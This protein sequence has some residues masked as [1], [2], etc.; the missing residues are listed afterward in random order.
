MVDQIE[1]RYP[2]RVAAIEW[3]TGSSYP[4][5]CA[6]ARARW[7]TYPPPYWYNGG[8]VYATPWAWIDGKNRG[9]QSGSWDG[10]VQQQ[11]ADSAE[12]GIN[13]SGDYTPG[14]G[15]GELT[16]EMVNT[17][18]SAV[19]ASLY[20]VITEDSLY[21]P[22][23]NGDA[24]HHHVCRDYVTGTAGLS[25]TIPA[26]ECDTVVQPFTIESSWL[27]R[28]CHVI[29]FLQNPTVQ[30]DS[31]RPIYQAATARLLSMVGVSEGRSAVVRG[32]RASVT[33]NPAQG[34]AT[35]RF[36]APAGQGYRLGVYALD[37]TLV[38]EFA[39]T[40]RS[41]ETSV[42]WQRDGSVARGVYAWRLACGGT[43]ASGKLV[44]TD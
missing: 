31:S 6:E 17:T 26:L 11:F 15:S 32:V 3:H 10:W 7:F 34:S 19:N 24:W 9:Y 25:V 38:Q 13:L 33:P 8:F 12:V 18:S 16:V 27:E 22:A 23:P 29:A 35:F 37:G 41:G 1:A 44:V 36:N 42:N 28:N 43:V 39:G 21:Y 5:Y 4:L 2:G 20:V 14:S 40:S 30:P